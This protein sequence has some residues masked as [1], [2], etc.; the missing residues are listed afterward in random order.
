MKRK[1][2]DYSFITLLFFY[3][4]DFFD[5]ASSDLKEL[6]E[7]ERTCPLCGRKF[8]PKRKDQEFCSELCEEEYLQTELEDWLLLLDEI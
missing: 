7:K 2:Q 6:P 5:V 8:H 3:R 4:Q 1:K